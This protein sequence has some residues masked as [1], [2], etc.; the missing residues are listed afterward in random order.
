L[1]KIRLVLIV[2]AVFLIISSVVFLAINNMIKVKDSVDY[3]NFYQTEDETSS[4]KQL[5]LASNVNSGFDDIQGN[6]ALLDQYKK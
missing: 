3:K 4:E 1:K 2:G 5:L 6:N